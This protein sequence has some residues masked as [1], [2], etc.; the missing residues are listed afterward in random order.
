MWVLSVEPSRSFLCD[1][2]EL[3]DLRME[4]M[5]VFCDESGILVIQIGVLQLSVYASTGYIVQTW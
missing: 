5:S 1:A 4:G 2:L 3:Y